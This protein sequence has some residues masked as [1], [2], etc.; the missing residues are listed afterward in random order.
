[1][2]RAMGERG[3]GDGL[4]SSNEFEFHR[5]DTS[6]KTLFFGADTRVFASFLVWR[7]LHRSPVLFIPD[8]S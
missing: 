4:R 3:K 8:T 2:T 5:M 7:V 1:M 6:W